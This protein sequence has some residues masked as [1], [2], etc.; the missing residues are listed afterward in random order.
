[1]GEAEEADK[2]ETGFRSFFNRWKG[3]GLVLSTIIAAAW[4]GY[5]HMEKI[6]NSINSLSSNM[7]ALDK[8]TTALESTSARDREAIVR[9]EVSVMHMQEVLRRI[10]N[11]IDQRNP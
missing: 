7:H 6:E 8:R 2:F 9:I 10:E 4:G 1:M 5:V 11:K 3:L